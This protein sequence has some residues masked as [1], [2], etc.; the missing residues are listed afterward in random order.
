MVSEYTVERHRQEVAIED[1][2]FR[3]KTA[4]SRLVVFKGWLR[5]YPWPP[6]EVAQ[7][8]SRPGDGAAA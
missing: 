3:D 2:G 7:A 6:R 5:H 8:W 4:W 1:G